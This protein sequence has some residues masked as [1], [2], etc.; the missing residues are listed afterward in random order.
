[1]SDIEIVVE[2]ETKVW[3]MDN[4]EIVG[5]LHVGT[6]DVS[7]LSPSLNWKVEKLNDSAVVFKGPIEEKQALLINIGKM[8]LNVRG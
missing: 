8:K 4:R 5:P 1:M 3:V 2:F 7:S 6:P